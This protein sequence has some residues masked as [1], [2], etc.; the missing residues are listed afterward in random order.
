MVEV[1]VVV[2]EADIG[3]ERERG[4][5][6]SS[7]DGGHPGRRGR[8]RVSGTRIAAGANQGAQTD[9]AERSEAVSQRESPVSA[10]AAKVARDCVLAF[11]LLGAGGQK[12][13]ESKGR[14]RTDISAESEIIKGNRQIDQDGPR[15]RCGRAGKNKRRRF[16]NEINGPT[17]PRAGRAGEDER[18][19]KLKDECQDEY[20]RNLPL[21]LFLWRGCGGC[22][23]VML[24]G[25]FRRPPFDLA[26]IL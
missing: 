11:T 6:A 24:Y 2:V 1:E 13:W 26:R 25:K 18:V 5:S 9:M 16:N 19:L 4:S 7:E 12:N 23:H 15:T 3:E 17:G 22:S 20:F 21:M 10:I 14:K 8:K